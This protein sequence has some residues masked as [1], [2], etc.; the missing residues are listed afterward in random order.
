MNHDTF[1]SPFRANCPHL[2]S[3]LPQ[4]LEGIFTQQFNSKEKETRSIVRYLRTETAAAGILP[5][6]QGQ[7]IWLQPNYPL[8][9]LKACFA[10]LGINETLTIV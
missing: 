4:R 1:Y 10:C 5:N 6:I 8:S 3:F 9:Y 2:K 7:E